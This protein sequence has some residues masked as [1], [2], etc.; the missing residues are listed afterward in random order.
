MTTV[1]DGVVFD[2]D[3][4]KVFAARVL[5]ASGATAEAAEL[6]AEVFVHADLG[7]TDTHGVARLNQYADALVAGR[8]S[9]QARP[10]VLSDCGAVLVVDA[11]NCLGPVGLCFATDLAVRA[12]GAH[13]VGV[14]AVRGSNHAGGMHWYTERAADAG[15]FAVVLTGSTKPMVVPTGGA[16]PFI[17][18]NAVAYG[19]RAGD[20]ALTFDASTSV[21]SRSKLEAYHRAGEPLPEGWALGADGRPASDA[22]EVIAGI[23]ALTGHGLLPFGG[24]ES[25]HKGFGVGLLVELLCGPIAGAR[26]GTQRD[27]SAADVGHFVLCL[28]LG[29]FGAPAAEVEKR[30][31]ALCA[32]L[33]AVPA[34]DDEVPV[35]VPGDRRR[36]CAARRG[37]DGIPVPPNVLAQLDAAAQRAGVAPLDR[38]ARRTARTD[39]AAR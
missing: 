4:L 17:G 31:E 1:T 2:A 11:R 35:R 24:A 12:A 8:V 26:W 19:V 38:R 33:R 22:G 3:E 10:E 39:R 15:L 9:G 29:A 5:A 21:A 20:A 30:V 28:D 25:G 13:G 7:G 23:D 16:A 18:T 32:G 34:A 14:V 6:C 36:E 37:A 27:P